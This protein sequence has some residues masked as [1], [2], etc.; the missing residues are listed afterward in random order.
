MHEARDGV[1]TTAWA[2]GL[3][4]SDGQVGMYGASYF[5]FTQWATATGKAPALKALFPFETW[6]DPYNGLAR[7]GAQAN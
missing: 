6:R 2:A 5:G 7:A 4:Y 3:P 1:D